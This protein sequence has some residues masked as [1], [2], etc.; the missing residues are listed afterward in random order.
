MAIGTLF[1]DND[2]QAVSLPN[3]A[4]FAEGV[5]KVRVRVLGRECIITPIAETWDSFF[6]PNPDLEVTEDFMSAVASQDQQSTW[7]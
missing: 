4:R 7:L 6:A 5:T 3:E 2:T 1:I